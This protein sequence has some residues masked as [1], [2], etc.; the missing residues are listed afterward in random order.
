M[1]SRNFLLK[2]RARIA[3]VTDYNVTVGFVQWQQQQHRQ[4]QRRLDPSAHHIPVNTKSSPGATQS[5]GPGIDFIIYVSGI[6]TKCG[7]SSQPPRVEGVKDELA[8][9]EPIGVPRGAQGRSGW[10]METYRK[11]FGEMPRNWGNWARAFAEQRWML[12]PCTI[13]GIF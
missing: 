4:H 2:Q 12:H 8:G 11:Q 6:L 3:P 9:T 1:W 10:K 7:H 13:K 5:G